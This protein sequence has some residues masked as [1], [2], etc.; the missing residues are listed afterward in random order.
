LRVELG[1]AAG[2]KN[3]LELPLLALCQCGARNLDRLAIC[4]GVGHLELPTA[5]N[6]KPVMEAGVRG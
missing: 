2:L 6:L 4:R 1:F 5:T 3:D